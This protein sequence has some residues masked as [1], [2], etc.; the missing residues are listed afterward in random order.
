MHV[1]T[2]QFTEA[3]N[4]TDAA[5]KLGVPEDEI[6]MLH[7]SIEQIEGVAK[8]VKLGASE[9]DRRKKRRRQQAQS[10]RANRPRR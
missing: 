7:G 10:R 3:R 4:R 1:P 2:G 5:R 6:V 9:L 8:R